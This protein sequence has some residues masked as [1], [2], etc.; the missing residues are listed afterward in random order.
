MVFKE[1]GFDFL[2]AK[3]SFL[4]YWYENKHMA[5]FYK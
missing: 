4:Y 2:H 5:K 3:R 1:T